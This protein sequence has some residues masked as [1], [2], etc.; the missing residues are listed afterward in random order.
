MKKQT[1]SIYLII[2]ILLIFSCK[3]AEI[4]NTTDCSNSP[5]PNPLHP[6]AVALQAIVDKY[7]K[8]GLPGISLMIK[9]S[10][11]TWVTSAGYASFEDK[12]KYKPCH[13]GKVGS[14]TKF[15]MGVLVFK[16]IEDSL[17]SNL[18]YND[19]DKPLTTW[20][21]KK[22]LKKIENAEE[23]TLRQCMN[24]STGIFDIITDSEFYLAVLNNPNKR[25]TQEELLKFVYG[26]KAAFGV[27]DTSGYSNTNTILISMVI[28]K[29]T[30]KKHEV[31]LRE[32]VLNPLGM[33]DTYYQGREDL[34]SFVTQGYYDL[35]NKKQLTNVSNILPGSGNGYNGIFSTVYDL[36]KFID[37]VLIDRTLLSQKSLF[38]MLTYGPP[39]EINNYGV[40]IMK[41][42][43]DRGEN[44]GIGHSGRDLGYT[45]DLFWFPTKN[46]TINFFIN[47][48][49]DSESFLKPVFRDFENELIDEMLK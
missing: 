30:G 14:I 17:N 18:G 4:G 13:I 25:W 8:K 45:A 5:N 22:I 28:E 37:A 48:G 34:P 41:K 46:F 1:L 26:R 39:D 38:K 31:L 16:L 47:Y 23:A 10:D 6:K 9:N 3:K 20:V 29:A 36:Q 35:Y 24:H 49:T 2:S 40:G 32:K 42:F 21:D 19:L 44:Y 27:G 7:I 33:A 43:N 15:M 12:I 11:G